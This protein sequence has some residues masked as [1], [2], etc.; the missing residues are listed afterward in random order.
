MRKMIPIQHEKSVFGL[1]K[2]RFFKLFGHISY[3]MM[4]TAIQ[5]FPR[6]GAAAEVNSS[7]IMDSQKNLLSPSIKE[8]LKNSQMIKGRRLIYWIDN[9]QKGKKSSIEKD[10]PLLLAFVGTDWCPWSQKLEKEILTESDFVKT[11]K[12][13][14]ILVWLDFPRKQ[15]CIP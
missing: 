3:I 6:I 1:S 2:Y 14:F 12:E 9:Y 11:L 8:A 10:K 13:N 5:L 15:F 7:I 4:A